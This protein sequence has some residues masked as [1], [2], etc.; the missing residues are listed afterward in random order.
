MK[1]TSLP[2]K[3]LLYVVA[4]NI[5]EYYDFLLFAHL[6]FVITPLFFPNYSSTHTHMLSL[7]LFG[8]SFVI[9]PIGAW[10][11]GYISDRR[12]RTT[13]LILSVQWAVFPA[14]GLALLPTYAT[15]GV[16]A[17][18][19]F[20]FLRLLQG[21]ALGGEYP[22]AGTYLMETY[23][24]QR[25]FIS[26]ILVASGSVGSLAGL[27]IA[28]L[29]LQPET[30]DWLWRVAF[31]LGGIGSL[32]SYR[33]RRL[34]AEMYQPL[35][36]AKDII[37][38]LGIRRLAVLTIGILGVTVWVPFTYSNFYVT[39][40]L[41]YPASQGLFATFIALVTYISVLPLMGKWYDRNIPQRFMLWAVAAVCPLTLLAFYLLTHAHIVAAQMIFS[42]AAA[43]CGAPV[44]ALMNA[45]FPAF[46][47]GR[48]VGPLF[49]LGLSFG[50]MYPSLSSYI[51]NETHL[52]MAPAFITGLISV[53]ACGVFY[54][55][56]RLKIS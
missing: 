52:D 14:L 48:N 55:L 40:V 12:G 32:I 29:C 51:V 33:L 7:A 36:I 23:R 43:G 30:P 16:V 50:G 56:K 28:A 11:F 22:V 45:L 42:I 24:N 13:A 37:P 25:G 38:H 4:G 44:H 49:M 35:T 53:A 20:V 3:T 47:R 39:K 31:L 54:R 19:A 6:G 21:I 18:Y 9:R 46:V 8:I 41:G 26:G 5:L 34:L 2:T 15:A 10:I 17:A 1:P 27:A